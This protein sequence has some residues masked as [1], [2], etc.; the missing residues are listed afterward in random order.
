MDSY[1]LKTLTGESDSK[2]Y[3][4]NEDDLKSKKPENFIATIKNIDKVYSIYPGKILYI[5]VYKEM[6]TVSVQ[7]SDFEVVRYLNLKNIQV[8]NGS[9][10]SAGQYLGE[11]SKQ[12]G[13]QFEYCTQWQ[14]ESVFPVRLQNV[15]TFKQNPIDLLEGKY[16][17]EYNPPVTEG[18]TDPRDVQ[19]LTQP[20]ID[21]LSNNMFDKPEIDPDVFQ[22][23]DLKDI[24]PGGIFELTNGRGD[25]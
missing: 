25:I 11:A 21:E 24:P 6:G 1:I 9:T 4:A 16:T 8:I 10:I 17:P 12:Y 14:G 20:E 18:Y 2:A 15:T 5:G 23:F 19:E 13:L 22:I 7:V 3:L